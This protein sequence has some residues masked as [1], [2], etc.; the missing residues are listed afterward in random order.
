LNFSVPSFRL[1]DRRALVIGASRGIGLAIAQA[2]AVAGACV[3]LCGRS[4]STLEEE[5][6]K[7][8]AAG[9]KADIMVADVTDI[10]GFAQKITQAPIFDILVNNAGTNRPKPLAETTVE[11]F[12]AVMNLNIR[13]LIF[14]TKAVTKRMM[15]AKKPGSIINISSQLGHVGARDRVTYCTSKWAMEGFTKALGVELAPHGIRVNSICP[16]FIETTLTKPYFENKDFYDEVISKIPLGTL[17]QVED[18]VGA[19]V[20][21]ASDAARL[22]TGSAVMVDGGWTAQ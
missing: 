16:T 10:E 8:V 15:K 1:D 22:I 12:D 21:L 7:L 20:F 6:A 18:I 2:F 14:A 11:D 4:H 17:G 9:F 13:S 3:T 5:A 19:A